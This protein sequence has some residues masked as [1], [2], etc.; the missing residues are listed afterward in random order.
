MQN[1]QFKMA[2]MANSSG[3]FHL[4]YTYPQIPQILQPK[5][6]I[7]KQMMNL[8]LLFYW[9]LGFVPFFNESGVLVILDPF[10][11]EG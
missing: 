5:K 2:Q 6:T 3:T 11:T 4:M 7:Q 10:Y 1:Y 8:Y 9:K